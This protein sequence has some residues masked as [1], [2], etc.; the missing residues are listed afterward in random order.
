MGRGSHG[1]GGSLNLSLEAGSTANLPEKTR[2][3]VGPAMQD[4]RA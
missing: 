1:R 3:A 2:V 4:A